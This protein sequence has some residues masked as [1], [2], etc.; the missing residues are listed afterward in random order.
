MKKNKKRLDIRCL[1]L[2][3][4][5]TR[6]KA[7]A[8]IMA[9][10]VEVNGIVVYESSY[11]VCDDDVVSIRRKE[12]YVSR[13]GLKL[14]A[15]IDYFKID[16]K[17]KTCLDVGVATGGFSDCMLQEGAKKVYG[18]DVGKGQV[19]EKILTNS[20]FVF[21][22]NMNARYLK[23]DIF[24]DE[25]DF[26]AVDVSFISLKL[27]IKPVLDVVRY[28]GGCVFLIKPQFELTKKDL[29]K[30]VV[31]EEGLRRKVVDEI[32]VFLSSVGCS[33]IIGFIDSPIEGVHGNKEFLLYVLKS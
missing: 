31:K 22:P 9:G 12:P 24:N 4:F 14:K 26:A 25:I 29:R 10:D 11:M 17:E 21:I 27:V 32:C 6:N 8:A 2:G 30:G 20:R 1:E 15:A 7:Q 18:I 3:L 19:H 23:K 5:K 13:A 16:L 28:G 33:K